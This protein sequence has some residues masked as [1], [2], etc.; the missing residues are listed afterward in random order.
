VDIFVVH[1][2]DSS[3]DVIISY[4]DHFQLNMSVPNGQIISLNRFQIL[5]GVSCFPSP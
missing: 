5:D 3:A 4:V 1:T 2:S